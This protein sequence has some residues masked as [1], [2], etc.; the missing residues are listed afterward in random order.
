M[1]R[2]RKIEENKHRIK[3]GKREIVIY[4][5]NECKQC[6]KLTIQLSEWTN[7]LAR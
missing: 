6:E 2:R 4:N 3:E 5:K 1:I 7:I